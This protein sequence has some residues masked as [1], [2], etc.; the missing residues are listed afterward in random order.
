MT[1]RAWS[2]AMDD[3]DELMDQPDARRNRLPTTFY[4]DHLGDVSRYGD[5]LL[6]SLTGRNPD[7]LDAADEVA[8]EQRSRLFLISRQQRLAHTLLG[9]LRQ[10]S[11]P[12][13][14]GDCTNHGIWLLVTLPSNADN[15]DEADVETL[16]DQLEG[17]GADVLLYLIDPALGWS[18]EDTTWVARLRT[19]GA[20]LL[21]LIVAPRC[22]APGSVDSQPGSIASRSEQDALA[23]NIHRQIGIKPIFVE[24]DGAFVSEDGDAPSD[25]GR[26]PPADVV[27]LMQR[28]V[29]LRPRVAVALAQD[30]AWCR[31][32]LARRIIRTG[33]L[34][35]ALLSAQPVPLLDLPFQVMLQWKVA[36]QLAAI[37]GRPGLDYRSGEMIGTIAW[38]LAIRFAM[39]QLARLVPVA[40]WL[41]S[42]AIGGVSTAL[43]GHALV[44]IYEN[45]DRW[46]LERQR[47][48]VLERAGAA[49]APVRA[50]SV[51]AAGAVHTQSEALAQRVSRMGKAIHTAWW[52]K[53]PPADPAWTEPHDQNGTPMAEESCSAQV[54]EIGPDVRTIAVVN[55]EP[56]YRHTNGS[57]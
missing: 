31:P 38:N 52:K 48:R 37:Y 54:D 10:E 25:R 5:D 1:R 17:M 22:A 41:L 53:A 29:S 8:S 3:V 56:T 43:L 13:C 14:L 55:L 27:A 24:I 23:A 39:Q 12:P 44:T 50:A 28:I 6:R 33:A 21:P 36:L 7:L 32:I 30:I 35:T 18:S 11:A 47:Q 16:L 15:A 26:K 2:Q 19:L 4:D 46:D 51:R 20:P 42:A 34:F 40:G 49:V 45:E 9:Y 57:R